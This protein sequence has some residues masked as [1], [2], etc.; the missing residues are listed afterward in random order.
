[1]AGSGLDF[2]AFWQTYDR[3]KTAILNYFDD[4]HTSAAVEGITTKLG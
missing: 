4:H 2:T 1:M 3:W